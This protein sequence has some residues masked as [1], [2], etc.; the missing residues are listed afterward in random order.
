MDMRF[1]TTSFLAG[2]AIAGVLPLVA[3]TA[4]PLAVQATATALDA[5]E[6]AQRLFA[7]RMEAMDDIL[8]EA[9][10]QRLA[11]IASSRAG[12]N[13]SDPQRKRRKRPEPVKSAREVPNA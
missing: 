8:A 2:L 12:G 4:R 13:G 10:M 9:R 7:E 6:Q 3:R 11:A 1:S 5:I